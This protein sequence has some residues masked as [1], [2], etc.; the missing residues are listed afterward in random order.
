MFERSEEIFFVRKES[1]KTCI[2]LVKK[3]KLQGKELRRIE[4]KKENEE[5]AFGA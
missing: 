5:I 3:K 2:K 4:E 1:L